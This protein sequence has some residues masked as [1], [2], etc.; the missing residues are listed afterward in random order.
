VNRSTLH[1]HIRDAFA[2]LTRAPRAQLTERIRDS[3]WGRPTAPRTI[4]RPVRVVP[5]LPRLPNMPNMP[6][7]PPVPRGL[8]LALV[9]AFLAIALIVGTVLAAPGIV[10]GLRDAGRQVAG[11]PRLL[12]PS[13]AS[14]PPA[15]AASATPSASPSA[16]PTR[17]ATP[18]PAPAETPVPAPAPAGPPPPA[19][20]P[21]YTCT[22]QDGG[23]GAQT[24]MTTARVG[25]QNG[26]DRFVVQFSG[27]VPQFEVRP[28]GSATFSADGGAGSV[29]LQGSAGL[30]VVLRNA[31]GS[32][33]FS[34][35]SDLQP[36]FAMIREARLLS[37]SQGVVQWAIGVAR[38]T[39]FHAWTL[40]GPTRL[41]VDVQH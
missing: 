20:L 17:E 24:S 14:R 11:I 37:D 32:G 26:F 6:E 36:G 18:T 22:A 4:V 8:P 7:L 15:P 21:G 1:H 33:S 12:A 13:Q 38:P 25:A 31:T 27:G 30:V 40:G 41:V 10:G 39:C 29:T 2:A 3:V 23:G 5:P 9:A 35:P 34:G 28:Q 16:T 19:P